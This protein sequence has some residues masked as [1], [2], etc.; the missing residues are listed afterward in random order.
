MLKQKDFPSY[1]CVHIIVELVD[2]LGVAGA[3]L[4]QPRVDATKTHV[5]ILLAVLP[6]ALTL[7]SLLGRISAFCLAVVDFALQVVTFSLANVSLTL[8][9]ASLAL[10]YVS[11]ILAFIH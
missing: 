5:L 2:R 1:L 10:A 9:N 11:R 3:V 7:L 8:A 4:Q 6:V